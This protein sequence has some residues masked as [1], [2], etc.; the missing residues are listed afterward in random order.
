[1]GISA[2]NQENNSIECAL[3]TN[4]YDVSLIDNKILHCCKYELAYEPKK[5]EMQKHGYKIFDN[6]KATVKARTEIANNI[7]TAS[8][9]DCWDYESKGQRSW[10]LIKNQDRTADVARYDASVKFNVQLSSLCNQ[11]C[12]YCFPVL[13]STIAQFGE[14]LDYE[15]G[16]VIAVNKKT[17]EIAIEFSHIIDFIDNLPLEKQELILSITG[18][19]PFI[20]NQFE[21]NIERAIKAFVTKDKNRRLVLQLSTNG[22]SKEDV[23]LKFYDKIIPLQKEYKIRLEIGIS[24]ENIEERAEY[25]R[26][27]LEWNVFLN[28][29]NI[30]KRFANVTI[31]PTFNVFSVVNAIDFIKFFVSQNIELVYGTVNQKY[32]RMNILNESFIPE[33]I[34]VEDYIIQTQKQHL[35]REFNVLKNFINNDIENAKIFKPSITNLDRIRKTD[36]TTVFPEYQQW[37]DNI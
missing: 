3:I 1:M 28:N 11:S 16:D 35:F 19:E 10:R 2:M 15:T 23:L 20:M 12:M 33:L 30:H 26:Q 5:I 34:K 8:C 31:K 17:K 9:R 22:N 14:W 37:F 4:A 25:V 13:S 32:L 18:G 36:W 24:L 7:K 27:G 29:F 21:E 6:N